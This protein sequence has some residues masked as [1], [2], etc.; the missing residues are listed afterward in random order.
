MCIWSRPQ[1]HNRGI[2]GTGGTCFSQV[3]VDAKISRFSNEAFFKADKIK[4]NGSECMVDMW[5][6]RGNFRVPLQSCQVR[7]DAV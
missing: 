3:F 4:G 1:K 2:K 6:R 7:K 5:E